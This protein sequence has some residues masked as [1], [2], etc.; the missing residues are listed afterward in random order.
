M[1]Y[2]F[3]GITSIKLKN[4]YKNLPILWAVGIYRKI[5]SKMVEAVDEVI[6]LDIFEIFADARIRT[7]F[8]RLHG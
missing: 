2:L 3:Y 4:Q 7:D 5:T 1:L 6:L 8:W